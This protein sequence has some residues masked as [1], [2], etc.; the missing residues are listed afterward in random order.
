MVC[1]KCDHLLYSDMYFKYFHPLVVKRVSTYLLI[2]MTI[3]QEI[4]L[5]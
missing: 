4:M 2:K 3:V 5:L 1:G